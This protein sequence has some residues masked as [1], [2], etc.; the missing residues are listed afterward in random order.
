MS[1]SGLVAQPKSMAR[2]YDRIAKE[3]F[4]VV[5]AAMEKKQPHWI[6]IAGG[7]GSGKSTVS[8]AIS[9]RLN[10]YRKD[11]CVVVPMD[12]YHYS[13]KD[14]TELH[15]PEAM[16]RRGA[17]FSF[18][19][20]RMLKDLREAKEK[21]EAELPIYDRSI[22]DPV[23]GGV[24]LK[25]NHLIVLVEGNYVLH[26]KDP[27]WAHLG[28]LWDEKWFIKAPTPEKQRDRLIGRAMKTWTKAKADRFGPG[29]AGA[30]KKA[31]ENDLPNMQ[32]I[33]YCEDIA[34]KVIV[35]E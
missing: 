18:D 24:L 33:A 1:T 34:T 32:I 10:Q 14:L 4:P 21:G 7:P 15:G 16:K 25:K 6:A 11:C 26:E 3:L 23:E 8:A 17:P 13:Q 31:D 30:A 35:T 27:R 12:G 29:R 5:D 28:E 20:E 2:T 9:E 22:S 19:A